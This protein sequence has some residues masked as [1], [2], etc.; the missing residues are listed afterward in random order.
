VL[1]DLKRHRHEFHWSRSYKWN[2]IR[3][4]LCVLRVV[5]PDRLRK[6]L[7]ALSDDY[8]PV[9]T[10]S[11]ALSDVASN[12]MT[13]EALKAFGEHMRHCYLQHD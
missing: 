9:L 13:A 8:V 3:F 1:P 4:D 12:E 2:V 6:E 5:A 7:I 10:L 11:E